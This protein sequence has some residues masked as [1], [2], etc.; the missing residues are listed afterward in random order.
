MEG[1]LG[2]MHFAAGGAGL[3]WVF[4]ITASI[5]VIALVCALIFRKSPKR[6][7]DLFYNTDGT[8][9]SPLEILNKRYCAGE[10][11]KEVYEQMKKEIGISQKNG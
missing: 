4:A 8:Q 5:I 11:D 9:A 6:P 1:T 2:H 3:S 7:S 10:I